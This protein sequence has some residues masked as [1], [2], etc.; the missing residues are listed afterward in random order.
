MVVQK[1]LFFSVLK[2]CQFQPEKA[3]SI[4][5]YLQG[6][7]L[8]LQHESQHMLQHVVESQHVLQ[9]VACISTHARGLM[10]WSGLYFSDFLK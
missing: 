1:Q 2:F 6:Q 8:P 7:P 5:L 10:V 9:R 3:L 4:F